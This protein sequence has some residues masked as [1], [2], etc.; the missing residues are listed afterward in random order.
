MWGQEIGDMLGAMGVTPI[1]VP[2]EW[3]EGNTRQQAYHLAVSVVNYHYAGCRTPQHVRYGL[4]GTDCSAG[5][6]TGY[7]AQFSTK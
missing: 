1:L 3:S 7:G 6:T 4:F 5:H 2:T